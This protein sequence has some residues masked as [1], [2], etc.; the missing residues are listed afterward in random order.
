ME[1]EDLA[2]RFR[3]DP[4][5]G[6]LF[7]MG[8]SAGGHLALHLAEKRPTWFAGIVL[9]YPVVT[10]RAG[11]RHDGSIAALLG[12]DRS[13]RRLREVSLERHVPKAMPPVFVWHTMDDATVP[14]ENTLRL[15]S[16]LAKKRIP[17][18]VHLYPRGTH[19]LALADE[20]TPWDD[21]DPKAYAIE[22]A[23]VASWFG[24]FASWLRTL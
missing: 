6:R 9:A 8:F 14:V 19:G 22:N 12:D 20:T 23:H 21:G 16:E 4:R 11:M 15:V 5:V 24:L 2:D 10:T 3:H 17:T 1:A 7:L 13:D 18:E